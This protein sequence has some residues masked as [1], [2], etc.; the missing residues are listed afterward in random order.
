VVV[1]VV[2]GARPHSR[3]HTFALGGLG[4][5]VDL[6]LGGV[7]L[8]EQLVQTSHLLLGLRSPVGE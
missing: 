7:G 8:E 1:V 4:E 5:G 2:R 3:Q 6:H